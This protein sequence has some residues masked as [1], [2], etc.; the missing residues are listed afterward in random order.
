[1]NGQFWDEKF[2]QTPSL[3]GAQPNEFVREQLQDKNPG[4][5][6]FP[7]EGEGRNALY[8]AS[9]GWKVTALDQSE[10]ARKHTL[11]SAQLRG[12]S[13]D[14]LVCKAEVFIPKPKSFDALAMIYFHL[15][16]N[17][18]ESVHQKFEKSLKDNALLIIEGFGRQQLAYT[19]GGPKNLEMLYDLEEIKSSFPNIIWEIEFDGILNLNEGQGHSGEGHI[20]RLLGK[21]QQVV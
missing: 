1:M 21:K 13:L 8:A 2:S 20:I 5:I 9:L 14:Y 17:I 7:G 3:Y 18:R 19:S 11:E 4:E 6:L 12:L 16:L 10:V 15:P